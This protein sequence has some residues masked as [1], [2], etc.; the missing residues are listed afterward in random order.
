MKNIS[1]L[2]RGSRRAH[3]VARLIPLPLLAATS[4]SGLLIVLAFVLM[5]VSAFSPQ[6]VSGFR[7]AVIDVFSPIINVVAL[8][9]QKTSLF[10]RDVSGL[11]QIQAENAR[12]IEENAKLREWYQTALLLEA[13]NKSLR[14]LLNVRIEPE[15][16]YITA[17]LL[18]DSGSA[19]A[20]SVLVSAGQKEG[21]RKG[22]AVIS[23]EGLVGRIVEVGDK[24]SRVLLINDM[25]SRVPILIE[26]TRQHAIFAGDNKQKGLLMHLPAESKINIGARI[27]TSGQGGLFP[28]GI[29]VGRI[30][31]LEHGQAH[32]EPFVDFSRLLHVRIV[33]NPE[34]PNL[35][36][37]AAKPS[38]N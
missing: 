1:K 26:D 38:F 13:E 25:N 6:A 30:Q 7:G 29:P 28:M 20:K 12:L 11:A 32:V 2:A 21:V 33:D 31:K 3:S 5:V 35:F 15:S 17:R 16:R 34:D 10:I 23:G 36:E 8:P 19:F 27:I 24:A 37:G 18:A 22:Q 14:E 4:A 9:V